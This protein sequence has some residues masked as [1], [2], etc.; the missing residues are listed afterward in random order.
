MGLIAVFDLLSHEAMHLPFNEGYLRMLR[1]AFPQDD[2]EFFARPGHVAALQGCFAPSDRITFQPIPPFTP[3]FGL[4]RHNPI[5]GRVGAWRCWQAMR[6]ALG[7]R[8]PRLAALLGV[9]ANLLAVLRRVWPQDVALHMILHNH[10]AETISWRS[11]NPAISAFDLTAGLRR[12]LPGRMR[13]IALELGIREALAEYA[14]ATTGCTEV[15]EHPILGG[16]WCDTKDLA[17][18]EP[19]RIGF[20]GHAS[21]SKGFGYFVDWATAHASPMLEFH[22]I[23]IASPEALAMDQTAL[24]RKATAGSVPRPEYVAALAPCHMVCLPLPQGYRTIAS[25]S[26]IDAIAGLKPILC[27]RNDAY[28]ALQAKY[29]EF[30]FM[31]DDITSLGARM[32]NLD[33]AWYLA[34]RATWDASL[35]RIRSARLPENLAPGYRGIVEAG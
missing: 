7:G 5:G 18:D 14:P 31:A 19:L 8:T 10:L 34:N 12:K 21:R 13:Y 11:R 27:Y 3:A 28:A 4:S 1:V 9:E 15:L 6:K 26:V 33:R 25:G 2:I 17:P 32:A 23:G 30:G 16:E 35:R 29:G 22:A 24:T 20:L